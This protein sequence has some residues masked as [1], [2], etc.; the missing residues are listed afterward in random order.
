R[1]LQNDSR[2]ILDFTNDISDLLRFELERAADDLPAL[3][4][5]GPTV[6]LALPAPGLSLAFGRDFGAS[7]FDRFRSG[8]MGRGWFDNFDISAATESSGLVTIHEG[9][10]VRFFGRMPDGSYQGFPG[11]MAHLTLVNGSLQ[12][13]ETTGAITAFRA[14]GTLDYIQDTNNNRITA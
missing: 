7:L 4:I 1:V 8:R 10:T 5:V 11:E 14:D 2:N 13:R 9:S 6:D 3:P 12:L